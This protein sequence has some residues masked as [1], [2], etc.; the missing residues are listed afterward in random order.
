M[1]TI[2]WRRWRVA[3][4][5]SSSSDN[6]VDHS[7]SLS[8][9]SSPPP[10]PSSIIEI[11][12]LP[13]DFESLPHEEQE[14]IITRFLRLL[15][16][17]PSGVL[18]L[19]KEAVVVDHNNNNNNDPNNSL[20]SL[21]RSCYRITLYT[22]A[23]TLNIDH[24]D[25]KIQHLLF[26]P[27]HLHPQQQQQ[28]QQRS[29]YHTTNNKIVYETPY[30]IAVEAAPTVA[31]GDKGGEEG[32]RKFIKY[33]YLKSMTTT[34]RK[35]S[36]SLLV[37][38]FMHPFVDEIMLRYAMITDASI[39][40]KLI[41]Y[42]KLVSNISTHVYEKKDKA[43]IDKMI[44]MLWRDESK[45]YIFSLLVK[46]S[47]DNLDTL[48]MKT[49]DFMRYTNL[50]MMKFTS[51]ICLQRA[52]YTIF[53]NRLIPDANV[54]EKRRKGG[55][56]GG[57]GGR[58]IGESNNNNGRGSSSSSSSGSGSNSNG[59]IDELD[60]TLLDNEIAEAERIIN[61]YTDL[62]TLA[63]FNPYT[64]NFE[65]FAAA[66][67]EYDSTTTVFLG[68]YRL[69]D[70]GVSS[71]PSSPSSSSSLSSPLSSSPAV[72]PLYYAYKR[73]ANYNML[74]IGES[75][76]GKSMFVKVYLKRL[77]TA[78]PN[79]LATIIDPS[80]EYN[81]FAK[82]KEFNFH[83]YEILHA[84]TTGSDDEDDEDG[85]DGEDG[86]D[87]NIAVIKKKEKEEGERKRK[88]KYMPNLDP[89]V[90]LDSP[91][92]AAS[93]LASCVKAPELVAKEFIAKASSSSNIKS[94][95]E[96]AEHLPQSSRIYI[97]DLITAFKPFFTS[98]P[99]PS[100]SSSSSAAEAVTT[101]STTTVRRDKL[102]RI[103]LNIKDINIFPHHTVLLMLL[104]IHVFSAYM[105]MP[106]SIPKVI[107]LDEAWLLLKD[108][109]TANL[110]EMF[111]RAGRKYN[112]H[113]ILITQMQS[114]V[115]NEALSVIFNNAS[116]K[117][118]FRLDNQEAQRLIELLKLSK[119]RYLNTLTSLSVGECLLITDPPAQN[120][121][122]RRISLVSNV[123]RYIRELSIIVSNDELELFS[124][125][126]TG[127]R[128]G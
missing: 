128:G 79:T 112:I 124:T 41:N 64:L 4:K 38:L 46:I 16:D 36:P 98:S 17:I 8:L 89:F 26:Q 3:K 20:L 40:E 5:G 61:A 110:V 114:D 94:I 113:F 56:G 31:V 81:V 35:I 73:Y 91:I 18:S 50:Y 54:K 75:G 42:E 2:A 96:F 100:P 74:V 88:G 12:L 122:L 52:L 106:L 7:S 93:M 67:S 117:V 24:T 82:L 28:V 105:R 21:P 57:G 19:R 39:L 22:H 101:T 60:A 63:L 120:M 30:E 115:S 27:P 53:E 68:L 80:G 34:P 1:T 23:K 83:V 6:A 37:A 58:G 127:G 116:T 47:A 77:I 29:R 33:L 71:P 119:D 15:I 51:S 86:E 111:I 118:F 25:P 9:P 13:L 70:V 103:I 65:E 55:E 126:P 99:S 44:E 87:D 84:S 11:P 10:P 66:S 107:V 95:Y 90:L 121:P 69:T 76:Y 104:L 85:E 62:Q 108:T 102:G 43:K 97:E 125:L 78:N 123:Q 109:Y 32:G 59:L 49:R 48:I 14:A 45:P 92:Q 72:L